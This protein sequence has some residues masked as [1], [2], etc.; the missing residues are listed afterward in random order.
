M[1]YIIILL[2]VAVLYSCKKDRVCNCTITTTGTTS[3]RTQSFLAGIDTTIRIPLNNTSASKVTFED[4]S[5]RKAKN[6]CFNK[7]EEFNESTPNSVSGLFSI[8]ITNSGTRSYDCT[9]D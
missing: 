9:L 3:T 1:K 5:K 6:N 8:T 2:I 4:V 7:S